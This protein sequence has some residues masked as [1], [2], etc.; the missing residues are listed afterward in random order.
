[1]DKSQV[2]DILEEIA[3]LLELKG[4]NPFK[5]RAY[6]NAARVLDQYDGDLAPLVA[7]NR[8]DIILGIGEALRLKITELVQTGRLDYY[9]K[10]RA[11]VPEGLLALIEIPALGPKK[12]KTLHDKLG[13]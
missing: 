8:L 10:L 6:A 9:E 13:I 5:A 11:S 1:M 4:E 2:S 7:E 3:V 12:I